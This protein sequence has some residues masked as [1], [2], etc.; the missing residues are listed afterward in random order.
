MPVTAIVGAQWGDE[1]KGKITDILA[2]EAD[3]VIRFGGGSNAGHTVVNER[4]EFRLHLIPSG[5]F[6]PDAISLVGSGTVVDFDFLSEELTQLSEAGVSTGGLRISSRA[7]LTMP[8]HLLLDRM[9]DEA[10]GT[11]AIGTTRR[12]VGPTYVDKADRVGIQAGDLLDLAT[13]RR[14][15]GQV[16]PA[17][18][19]VLQEI[20]G[21]PPLDLDDLVR[22]AQVWSDRFGEIVV[23]PVPL[24]ARMLEEDRR[25]LLEGQLGALRDLDWGTY[26]YVTSST[27]IAG[28]GGVGGGIPP[29]HI[30]RV[31]G[32]VKAYTT[33]VGAG[34]MPC[35]LHGREADELREKGGEYGATTGRPR[36]V[37]WFDAVA[38]RYSCLLNGFT[39]I[40]VTKLDVLDGL[41]T[42]R[43]CTAYRVDGQQHN[44]VPS[45][46]LLE[47][48]TPEYEELPGWSET[49][50]AAKSW[51]D[52]PEAARAYLSRI[53]ELTGAPVD[54]VSVGKAREETIIGPRET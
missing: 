7:H 22:R 40:A 36:R 12:G 11:G 14:K 48:A 6:N 28:G 39:G 43:I 51:A 31:V 37:G 10:R 13:L 17:K 42:L 49:T 4:G 52:L 50:T 41:P 1:G 8:Y 45:T 18:N 16:L 20:Y 27:T 29:W 21:H 9:N 25:I 53:E 3:I 24:I 46:A 26:P 33:A 38:T 47:R 54:I 2:Q 35:E 23:D 30:R 19:R 5:I 15:L 44:T 34:P 32:V